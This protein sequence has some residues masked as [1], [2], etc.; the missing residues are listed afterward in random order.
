MS[1]VCLLC[2]KRHTFLQREG[3]QVRGGV[4]S[5]QTRAN[6]WIYSAF[7]LA[8]LRGQ[9]IKWKIKREHFK[10]NHKCVADISNISVKYRAYV[11]LS[12]C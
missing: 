11:P 6:T 12:N 5:D 8:N 9:S 7:S 4:L 3:R 10:L 1:G 2:E